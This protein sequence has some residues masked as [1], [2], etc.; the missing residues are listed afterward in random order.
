MLR[1][2]DWSIGSKDIQAPSVVLTFVA[3]LKL[4]AVA[5]TITSFCGI[6]LS[7]MNSTG[8]AHMCLPALCHGRFNSI[9]IVWEIAEKRRICQFGHLNLTAWAGA[10]NSTGDNALS[11][12]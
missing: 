4:L 6:L 1:V 9:A 7:R 2:R 5:A 3:H 8:R 11:A 10:L 12:R